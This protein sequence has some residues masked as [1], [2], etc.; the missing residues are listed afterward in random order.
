M[1]MQLSQGKYLQQNI[2][3]ITVYYAMSIIAYKI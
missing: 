2:V 1:V 3:L